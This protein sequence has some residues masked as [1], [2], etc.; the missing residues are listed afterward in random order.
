MVH[1]L[2]KYP[3]EVGEGILPMAADLL[4]E[5]VAALE[6]GGDEAFLNFQLSFEGSL[7]GLKQVILLNK[8][9]NAFSGRLGELRLLAS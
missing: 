6:Q 3:L 1:E 4:D 9:G 5:G 8:L 7:L 2:L